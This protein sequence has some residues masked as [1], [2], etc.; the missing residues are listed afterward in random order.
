[1]VEQLF[2]HPAWQFD[3][4]EFPQLPEHPAEQELPQLPLVEAV[5]TEEQASAQPV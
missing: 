5:Q 3:E 2:L 4:H 1:M